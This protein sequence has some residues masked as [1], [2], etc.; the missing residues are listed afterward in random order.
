MNFRPKTIRRL[1]TLLVGCCVLAAGIAVVVI[2]QLR[3]YERHQQTFRQL[4]M[5]AYQRGDYR[6]AWQNLSKYLSNDRIDSEAIFASAVSRTRLPKPDRSNLLDARNQFNRYL[7][8]NDGDLPARHELLAIYQKLHYT[9][10]SEMLADQLLKA[11]PDDIPALNAKVQ[12]LV[13][14]L[15]YAAALPLSQHLNDLTPLDL[16]AQ[17]TTYFLMS[18]QGYPAEALI[19]RADAMLGAHPDDARFEL[20]RAVAAYFVNEMTG[21]RQWLQT[22]ARRIPTDADF[23]LI[24]VSDFD[25]MNMWSDSLE[26]LKRADA[27]PRAP[28]AVRAALVQRLWE[29][30]QFDAALTQLKNLTLDDPTV[31]S[32]LVG[33]HALIVRDKSPAAL[34][35]AHDL[36]LLTSRNEDLVASGWTL[37]FSALSLADRGDNSAL[38]QFVAAEHADPDNP[39][40]R[41]YLAEEYD[42]LGES[43]LAVQ[44]LKQLTK[45]QPEWPEPYAR[46]AQILTRRGQAF[47]AVP[48]ATAACERDPKSL[49]FP[50]VLELAEYAQLSSRA[51]TSVIKPVLDHLRQL[52]AS[53]P[54]DTELA[55]QE[56][57]LLARSD[58]GTEALPLASS[59]I[60]ST[61]SGPQA[62]PL[63]GALSKVDRVNQLGL[64]TQLVQAIG[65]LLE[66]QKLSSPADFSAAID[67]YLN[68]GQTS[69]AS[70]LLQMMES[71]VSPGWRLAWLG[72]RDKMNDATTAVDWEKFADS[73]PD[74]LQ[75]QQAAAASSAAQNRRG[76]TERS[77]D[78]IRRLTCDDGLQWK[79]QRARWL[80]G[81]PEEIKNHAATAAEL[82]AE[83]SRACPDDAEPRVIAA[84]AL[85]AIG[86]LDGAISS[87]QYARKLQPQNPEI[88]LKLASLLVH[89]GQIAQTTAI[90]DGIE[91]SPQ[92]DMTSRVQAARLYREAGNRHQALELLQDDRAPGIDQPDR[93]MLLAQLF[94]EQGNPRS[95]DEIY[96][97]WE[98]AASPPPSVLRQL[99]FHEASQGSID[100][101]RIELAKLQKMSLPDGQYEL[102][103]GDFESVYGS[104]ADAG[105]H[106]ELAT[107]AAPADTK[108]WLSWAGSTLKARNF[109]NSVKIANWGLQK[110]PHD[111]VLSA[112][113]D[114]ALLMA[115]LNW[116]NE[117]QPLIDALAAD[118]TFKPA[119]ATLA[120][121]CDSQ[122]KH[123]APAAL[124]QRLSAVSDK[125]PRF[126]PALSLLVALDC[127]A[128]QYDTAIAAATR[129]REMMPIDAEPAR[130]VAMIWSAAGHWQ[131]ALSA[132]IDWRARSLDHPQAADVAIAEVQ[133]QMNRAND[134][135]DQLSPY[136]ENAAGHPTPLNTKTIELTARALCMQNRIAQARKLVD[137]MLATSFDWRQ[138]WLTIVAQTS[139]DSVSVGEQIQAVEDTLAPN[140][141]NDL[142][143]VSR[144]WYTAGVRLND[145]DLLHKAEENIQPLTD[146]SSVPAEAWLLL[147]S[148]QMHL[149]SLSE[150]EPTLAKAVLLA[151]AQMEAKINLAR[152]KLL[153]NQDLAAARALA[154]DACDSEPASSLHH[155]TLGEIEVAMT[156]FDAA[157]EQ[158]TTAVRLDPQNAEGLICLA[159][160]QSKSNRAIDSATTLKHAETVLNATHASLPGFVQNEMKQLRDG[161]KKPA[162][163]A[164]PGPSR[165]LR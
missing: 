20:L 43:Q 137:P 90:L 114:R 22:A 35:F 120:A 150:A 163:P 83:V 19:T 143:A 52:R 91:T 28:V 129:A 9:A 66:D 64:T 97:R 70:K 115:G 2:V 40:I 148:I 92:F 99:A 42:R 98:D 54:N 103:L 4:G 95:A 23:T 38:A 45:M 140:A 126:I 113:R 121:I 127:Q 37:L 29:F 14:D 85:A 124:A 101:A 1:T 46:I 149:D 93:D 73:L 134:A 10:E 27:D 55:I 157:I 8:L 31:D 56:V 153:R 158:L 53:R 60:A 139:H 105:A 7:E 61:N 34:D 79:L 75:V 3:R 155:M 165:Y 89:N 112:M 72:A 144:A 138:R 102:T 96:V 151:P 100:R 58:R 80:L 26:L 106:Y 76:L 39:D 81:A 15:N 69:Q 68:A 108:A 5:D 88:A 116:N 49:E 18:R 63:L 128:G 156:D 162:V 145:P 159:F 74:D 17:E 50:K 16:Q 13:R 78:R 47:D 130:L 82:M 131:S 24:L 133:L 48:P 111:P 135:I 152:V 59:I 147:G 104:L 164:V 110:L 160:A 32:E 146:S 77:I 122:T 142:L 109:G 84:D 161:V 154:S 41:F 11:N 125:Y 33:L 62:A 65:H 118:P 21:A 94:E 86:D 87:L 123:E 44:C 136:L 6:T 36:K 51:G 30:K 117:T 71:K 57:D 12:L 25:R 132:A 107:K 141:I 67:V 119:V